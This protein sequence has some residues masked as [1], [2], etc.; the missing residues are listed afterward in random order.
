MADF[1]RKDNISYSF[2]RGGIIVTDADDGLVDYNLES[3]SEGVTLTDE[4]T[5]NGTRGVV[6]TLDKGKT[7]T[8]T[9]RKDTPACK[10][11]L[12]METIR[13]VVVGFIKDESSSDFSITNTLLSGGLQ[14]YPIQLSTNTIDFIIVGNFDE[15]II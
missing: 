14:K 9:V 12:Q 15:V 2:T 8:L 10:K 3:S 7:L 4:V 13:S 1:I 6:D 5:I 11:L